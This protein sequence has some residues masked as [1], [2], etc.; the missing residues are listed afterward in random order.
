MNKK[1]WVNPFFYQITKKEKNLFISFNININL[2]EAHNIDP[3]NNINVIAELCDECD[4]DD[5]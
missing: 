1:K 4:A 5:P 3:I 2:W